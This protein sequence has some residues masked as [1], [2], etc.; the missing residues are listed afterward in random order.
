MVEPQRISLF[1]DTLSDLPTY[2]IINVINEQSDGWMHDVHRYG[3]GQCLEKCTHRDCSLAGNSRPSLFS[4]STTPKWRQKF[5]SLLEKTRTHTQ[6]HPR[7][8]CALTS[9]K[10]SHPGSTSWGPTCSSKGRIL[11]NT[12]LPC[13]SGL[14]IFAEENQNCPQMALSFLPKSQNC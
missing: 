11:P 3:L 12:T 10:S 9:I 8:T 1:S 14:R 6:A 4:H 13:C 7:T 5:S 2:S